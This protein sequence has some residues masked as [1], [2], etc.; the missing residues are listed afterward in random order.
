[1][2]ERTITGLMLVVALIHLLPTV[3]FFLFDPFGSRI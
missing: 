2:Y 3:L 1:M